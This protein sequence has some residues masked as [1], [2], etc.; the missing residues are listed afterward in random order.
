MSYKKLGVYA[1][2]KSARVKYK[3]NKGLLQYLKTI[4]LVC[5]CVICAGNIKVNVK[6]SFVI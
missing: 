3:V 4:V 2:T 6:S 1:H 5:V